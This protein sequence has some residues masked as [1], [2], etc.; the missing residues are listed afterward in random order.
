M[1]PNVL[2]SSSDDD[3]TP[4]A[5]RAPR[6]GRG[7]GASAERIRMGMRPCGETR[8]ATARGDER[9]TRD[10]DEREASSSDDDDVPLAQR[11]VGAAGGANG[12][13][14]ASG[15]APGRPDGAVSGAGDELFREDGGRDGGETADRD[16]ET[17]D[18]WRV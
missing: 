13:T 11:A 10:R 7:G 14:G 6:G 1:A 8:A 18:W 5:A 15:G 4:L 12:G 9:G 3:E 16:A 2:D 17:A